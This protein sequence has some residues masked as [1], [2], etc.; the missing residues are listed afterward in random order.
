MLKE[1]FGDNALGQMQSYKWFKHFKNGQMSVNDEE[2]SGDLQLEPRPKMWQKCESLSL[3]T[4]NKR[5]ISFATLPDCRMER[6]S[7]FCWMSST[8]GALQQNV[9]Q[10]C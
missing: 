7:E 5:F 2:H 1:A 9:S 10:R 8:C 6:A 3:K 4:D